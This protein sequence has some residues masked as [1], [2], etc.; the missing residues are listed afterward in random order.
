MNISVM[1]MSLSLGPLAALIAGILILAVPRLLNYI[2]ALY[3][4]LIGILGLVGPVSQHL[5]LWVRRGA[6]SAIP[7]L[8]EAQLALQRQAADC[9]MTSTVT[10][11]LETGA[12]DEKCGRGRHVVAREAERMRIERKQGVVVKLACGAKNR[13]AIDFGRVMHGV[14]PRGEWTLHKRW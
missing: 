4:V 7:Q 12:L 11:P 1:N 10:V 2:V 14:N 8:F 6:A 5:R 3:L 13:D 9:I